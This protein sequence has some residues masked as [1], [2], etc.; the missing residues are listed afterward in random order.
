MI[1][2]KYYLSICAICKNESKYLEEW[3]QYH[4]KIGIE[5]F[6]L[7]ENDSE[8]IDAT[9][10]IITKLPT[11]ITGNQ[12]KG[13]A[14][15]AAAYNNC[16]AKYKNDSRWI[17]FIDIDEFIVPR[18][19]ND[20]KV[21][22]ENYEDFASLRIH[23]KLFGS[24]GEL[25][26]K[27][28]PVIERFTHC[29]QDIN[30]H[31]KAIVNPL[32]TGLYHTPHT[33]YQHG[34]VVNENKTIIEDTEPL[35]TNGTCNLIQI[36]HYATKSK[37]ECYLRKSYARADTGKRWDAETYFKEHDRNEGQDLRALELWNK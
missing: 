1:P 5:H 32:K 27:N 16:I 11:L 3:I 34:K 19:T 28:K 24:N 31:V 2:P 20:L 8:P 17:A 30:P 33:F 21:F 18:K 15:Q 35:P 6:Y 29:Q 13:S 7:Y 23:W 26:Y 22:L 36:N 10:E 14:R 25:E 12:I 9:W 4:T 37:E